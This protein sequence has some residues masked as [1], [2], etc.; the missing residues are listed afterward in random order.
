MSI[1]S[2]S[3]LAAAFMLALYLAVLALTLAGTSA[4]APDPPGSYATSQVGAEVCFPFQLWDPANK[5]RVPC[6]IINA[7]Q[8]DG[9]GRLYLG[10]LSNDQ[11]ECLIPNPAEE[12]GRF[13]IQCH[14]VRR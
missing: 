8:E 7:P 5:D 6:D 12:R 13:T 4:A 10:T 14:R 9:S 3:L 2:K 1:K 11:A